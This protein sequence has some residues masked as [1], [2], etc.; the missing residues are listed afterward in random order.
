M[1]WP[2][3]TTPEPVTSCGPALL[4]GLYGSGPRKVENTLTT[5]FSTAEAVSAATAC[6]TINGQKERA[7]ASTARPI[8]VRHERVFME[9]FRCGKGFK[10]YIQ[11]WQ[12]YMTFYPC[13]FL[14]TLPR[15]TSGRQRQCR[16]GRRCRLRPIH[17][18]R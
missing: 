18:H 11:Q 6:P 2:S 10:V 17:H 15:L 12:E 1:R 16:R 3:M 13:S 7:N 5:E 8:R 9:R 4:H 14:T